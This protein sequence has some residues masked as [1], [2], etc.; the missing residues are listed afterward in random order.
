MNLE[1]DADFDWMAVNYKKLES[2]IPEFEKYKYKLIPTQTN[3]TK[4]LK[5]GEVNCGYFALRS[6]NW[7]IELW[8]VTYLGSDEAFNVG[9]KHR[10]KALIDGMWVTVLHSPAE[11]ARNEYGDDIFEHVEH[12][13]TLA[14]TTGWVQPPT[15]HFMPCPTPGFHGCLD[16]YLPVGN[17]QFQD[18][19]V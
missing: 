3:Y 15:G 13:S 7:R 17:I 12:W 14:Y 18:V 6:E 1:R 10:T 2:L 4:C 9:L 11:S 19:W 5:S 8:G 16:M